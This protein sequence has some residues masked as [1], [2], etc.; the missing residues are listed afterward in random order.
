MKELWVFCDGKN[1]YNQRHGFAAEG[2]SEYFKHLKKCPIPSCGRPLTLVEKEIG[3]G[4]SSRG[5]CPSEAWGFMRGKEIDKLKRMPWWNEMKPINNPKQKK[6]NNAWDL[7]EAKLLCKLYII[8]GN[9]T[10]E[11]WNILS[12]KIGRSLS[13]VERQLRIVRDFKNELRRFYPD[14]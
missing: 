5:L 12:S 2:E 7:E 14:L 6:A 13:A 8:Y 9:A 1:K 4:K 10:A 3:N 11:L